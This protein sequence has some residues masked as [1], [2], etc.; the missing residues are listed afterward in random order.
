M[1]TDLG[2]Q[3]LLEPNSGTG[4][5]EHQPTVL[6][7]ED[8]ENTLFAMEKLLTRAG[9]LVLTAGGGHDAI[10]MLEHP[11]SP[12]DVVVLDVRLPD[13]EGA[14]LGARMRELKPSLPIV[15]CTG[16]AGLDE[17][18]ALVQLGGVRYFHKPVRA[19]ELLTAVEKAS[20]RRSN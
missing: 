4:L 19:D 5:G 8:D 1:D 2:S 20:P 15:V 13:V 6:L 10:R 11:L 3:P 17:V 7:V 16:E 9:Y 18:A 12:I 14:A